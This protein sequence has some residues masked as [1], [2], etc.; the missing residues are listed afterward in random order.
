V[1]LEL[2]TVALTVKAYYFDGV[3]V[4]S[5]AAVSFDGIG[6]EAKTLYLPAGG[7]EDLQIGEFCVLENQN[8]HTDMNATVKAA[9]TAGAVD[10]LGNT[11]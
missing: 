9:L 2:D 6:G 11:I 10:I 3:T 1:S 5:T 8:L 7:V 4:H